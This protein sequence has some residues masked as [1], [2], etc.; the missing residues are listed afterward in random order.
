MNRH[1][2]ISAL[3]MAVALSASGAAPE[4]GHGAVAEAK[5]MLQKAAAHYK[6][7]GRAQALTDFSASKM[8]FRDRDLYVV[9]IGSDRRIS[10]NGAFPAYVGVSADILKDAGARRSGTRSWPQ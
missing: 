1:T 6:E 5:A 8:P 2:A 4:S 9:C 7:V 10:A 3:L